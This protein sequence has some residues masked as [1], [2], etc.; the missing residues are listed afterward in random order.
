[1]FAVKDFAASS[2]ET[3]ILDIGEDANRRTITDALQI[4][5]FWKNM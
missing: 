2:L 5:T 4:R 1:M 3:S